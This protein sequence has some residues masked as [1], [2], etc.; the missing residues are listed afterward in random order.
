MEFHIRRDLR[1]KLKLDDV[2]FSYTGNVVFANVT[3][4]RK[5]AAQ[6]NELRAKEDGLAEVA[7]ARLVNAGALFA[8][9]L[10]D[11]LNHALIARYRKEVDPAV[12]SEGVK[13]FAAQVE[14][15]SP[16][17]MHKLLLAFTEQFPNTAIYRGLTTAAG[18]LTGETEGLSNREAALEELLLLW[19]ANQNPALG[20]FKDLFGDTEL[21]S[22]TQYARITES[23]PAFFKTRPPM[24]L[25]TLLDALRAPMLASPDSLTGQLDF[26]REHWSPYLGNDLKRVLLAIDTLREEDLAI[27]MRFNPPKPDW[28]R[29]GAP[30]RGGEGF[31]GDEY[32]G[33]EEEWITDAS[34]VRRR[35]YS[36]DYQA[37]LNEYEAFSADQ[38]WMP[39][40]VMIAKSTYVWL[41]QL[42]KKY[43][44]HI[45]RL[46]QVPEEEMRLL[47]ERGITS[48][49]L[50][51]LWE[52]STA[53]RTI[54]HLRGHGDAVA[55]AYSLKDYSIA[56]D[57]GGYGAYESLK[58][59]ASRYG[60]RLASDMVPNHMGIDFHMGHRA[61]GLV[62]FALGEP[63]PELQLQRP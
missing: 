5:L 51:G 12:L 61:S 10:I 54:K 29:H 11:E 43:Q 41:E 56:E 26:I 20:S 62:S 30:G 14:K 37:P 31:V 16:A 47:A 49:W 24:E 13:W 48:L 19:L 18:W 52:R 23:F 28:Y 55:S 9:G 1:D 2:L 59:Q 45:H 50:I 4:S 33:F 60:L 22:T 40:V 3:A 7:P 58:H 35:R 15:T 53:S 8:M 34:G 25:G 36:T 39:N 21:K 63:V 42:S 57:L 17:A 27:W 32:I 44:R 6:M 46:D 38:A